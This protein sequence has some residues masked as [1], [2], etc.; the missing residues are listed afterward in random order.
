M[1]EGDYLLEVQGETPSFDQIQR[2]FDAIAFATS[3]GPKMMDSPLQI[4]GSNGI[5]HAKVQFRIEM[6]AICLNERTVPKSSNLAMVSEL[7]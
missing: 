7:N 1:N 2:S 5:Q 6:E 3:Q 4:V